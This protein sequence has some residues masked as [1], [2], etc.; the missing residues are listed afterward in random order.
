MHVHDRH[1]DRGFR[2]TEIRLIRQHVR[3]VRFV[4]LREDRRIADQPRRQLGVDVLHDRR[5][6]IRERGLVQREPLVE[7]KRMRARLRIR[8]ATL[9]FLRETIAFE[10]ERRSFARAARDDQRMLLGNARDS[11][12]ELA[13]IATRP[14]FGFFTHLT[15]AAEEPTPAFLDT[16]IRLPT[17]NARFV[18][19]T[20]DRAFHFDGD[21]DRELFIGLQRFR[22][23]PATAQRR[24]RKTA[25]QSPTARDTDR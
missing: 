9:V 14:S 5:R 2:R 25:D 13:F 7:L 4:A 16:M 21:H 12:F 6:G 17:R 3:E 23:R 22:T 15:E 18:R 20:R 1:P 24:K 8:G 11:A 19:R 10:P